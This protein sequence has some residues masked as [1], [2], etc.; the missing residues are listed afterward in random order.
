M[1]NQLMLWAAENTRLEKTI[2]GNPLTAKT[3]QRFVAG[4][5]SRTRSTPRST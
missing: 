5:G 2:A 1:V 4:A 3:V